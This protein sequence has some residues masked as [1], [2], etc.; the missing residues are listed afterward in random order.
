MSDIDNLLMTIKCIRPN[1]A[2]FTFDDS[3]RGFDA[4]VWT[5]SIEEPTVQAS[6]MPESAIKA[7][8]YESTNVSD[9]QK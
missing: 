2:P 8:G 7:E 5:T 1:N 4:S 6:V 3:R 9:T